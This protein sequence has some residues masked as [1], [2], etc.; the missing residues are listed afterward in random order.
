MKGQSMSIDR[1]VE[2]Q[3]AP[4]LL[5]IFFLMLQ[6]GVEVEVETGCSVKRLL[7]EQ[8]GISSDYIANRITTL[9]LNS[10]AVD[11]AATALVHDDAV[12]ALSGAMPGLVGATMRS[13]GYYAA[14]R[15]A[16]TFHN[17]SDVPVARRGK[18]KLKLFNLLLN[19]L[20]PR[21]LL[22]GII[23]SRESLRKFF[24][25]LP[26]DF[27]PLGAWVDGRP[28]KFEQLQRDE[29]PFEDAELLKLKI[30]FGVS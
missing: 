12:L 13:G 16:M 23:L 25:M 2:L 27:R 9:F 4:E 7:T 17:E 21:V 1:S 10:K 3:L 24:A 5:K 26:E 30:Q 28:A 14:M 15:G 19:E 11:N 8:F 20:G 18:I 29:L 22:R 6:Q